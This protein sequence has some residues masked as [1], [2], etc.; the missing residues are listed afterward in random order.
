MIQHSSW[1]AGSRREA[2]VRGS[3]RIPPVAGGLRPI[4]SPENLHAPDIFDPQFTLPGPAS[5]FID[6]QAGILD[7]DHA[8][9]AE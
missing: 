1:P 2:E 3:S 4:G 9:V 5:G 6:P 8:I 7:V